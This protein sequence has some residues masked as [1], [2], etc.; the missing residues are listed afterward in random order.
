MGQHFQ[1]DC[2]NT[3]PFKYFP[4]VRSLDDDETSVS[5]GQVAKLAPDAERQVFEGHRSGQLAFQAEQFFDV[6]L[7]DRLSLGVVW[8]FEYSTMRQITSGSL[9]SSGMLAIDNSLGSGWPPW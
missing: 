9:P 2:K 6:Y 8:R 5:L 1:D 7:L 4:L 3:Q